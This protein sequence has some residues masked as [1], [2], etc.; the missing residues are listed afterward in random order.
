MLLEGYASYG[1]GMQR[2]NSMYLFLPPV[3]YFLFQLLLSVPGA[4][5]PLLRKTSMLV[6]LI[7][8]AV[9][10]AVRGFAKLIHQTGLFV[11]NSLIHYLL[12][13]GISW[14]AAIFLEGGKRLCIKKDAHGSN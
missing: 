1:A 7:H 11:T 14:I 3:M 8:P 9:I 4:S 12:V 2:H 6:Y 10:L 5:V 13:C